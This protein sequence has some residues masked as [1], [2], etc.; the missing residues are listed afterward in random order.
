MAR[1]G[2]AA[3]KAAFLFVVQDIFS[4]HFNTKTNNIFVSVLIARQNHHPQCHPDE[5]QDLLWMMCHA[6]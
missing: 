4:D 3:Q 2:K 6:C 5:D 1:Y